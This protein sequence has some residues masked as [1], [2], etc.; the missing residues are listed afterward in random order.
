MAD[1]RLTKKERREQRRLEQRRQEAE[2]AKRDRRRRLLTIIGAVVAVAAIAAV[3]WF[4]REPPVP[5]ETIVIQAAEAEE[6]A[7]AAGCEP[8]DVPIL[9]NTQ[10]LSEPAPPASELYP[11]RPTSTGPHFPRTAP[12]GFFDEYVDERETTHNLEHGSV[13]A[14]WDPDGFQ[15]T[16]ALE[17][18]VETR[19][20][21]GFSARAGQMGAGAGVIAAPFETDL[22]SGKAL[23]FRAWGVAF[24]CDEFNQ[25]FADAFLAGNYGT[26][27][28]APERSLAPF[29]EEALRIEGTVD[30][31]T[32]G[33]QATSEATAEATAEATLP[34]EKTSPEASPTG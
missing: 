30:G 6:A 15:E 14:W 23:A 11:V 10:H 19:N 34:G 8:V 17:E 27:G 5:Q 25:T 24:A 18:W 29:P 31:A 20:R 13:I 28:Q 9:Q 26:H 12:V 32:P 16:G 3:F 33:D 2:E 22:A 4:T 1:E 7:E 21:M